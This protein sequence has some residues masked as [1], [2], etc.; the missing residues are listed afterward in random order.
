MET[1]SSEIKINEWIA[2]LE[3]VEQGYVRLVWRWLQGTNGGIEPAIP[4][5]M[6]RAK[7]NILKW[8]SQALNN[9]ER[10]RRVMEKKPPINFRGS[11]S[12]HKELAFEASLLDISLSEYLTRCVNAG[13][14]IVQAYPKLSKQFEGPVLPLSYNTRN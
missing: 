6:S 11:E 5:G 8:H 14:P 10:G 7:A 4:L 2:L 12:Y 3:P 1:S 9:G 13:R